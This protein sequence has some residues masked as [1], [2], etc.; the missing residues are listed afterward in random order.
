M[1]SDFS[2]MPQKFS[3]HCG[4]KILIL[5]N[6][7]LTTLLEIAKYTIPAIVVLI[8]AYTIIQRFLGADVQRKQ[9]ELLHDTQTVT[10]P[11]RLQA[12][13]RLALF[14]ERIHFRNLIPRVYEN[15]MTVADFKFAL[16][17][18]INTEYEHNISQQIYVSRQIW[19]TVR[20][21]KEQELAMI[22]QLSQQLSPEASA[23]ELQVKLMDYLMTAD[24]AQPGEIGLQMI[25][26]EARKVLSFGT[27][28]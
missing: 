9:L 19:E 17:L 12:Y 4:V 23:R 24:D 8:A 28:A 18:T 15:G 27:Q 20:H 14:V 3:L 2:V 6:S 22:H 16:L 1:Q 13:E 11:L 7:N 26:E 5:V 21:A 25:N 10:I